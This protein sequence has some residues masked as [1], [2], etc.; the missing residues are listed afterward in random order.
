LLQADDYQFLSPA[1]QES[2][3]FLSRS[4][5]YGMSL[6]MSPSKSHSLYIDYASQDMVNETGLSCST[7]QRLLGVG[8]SYRLWYRVRIPNTALL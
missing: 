3:S 7:G 1:V 2:R 4:N 6:L 8:W 5:A